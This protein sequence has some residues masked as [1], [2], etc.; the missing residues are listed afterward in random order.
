MTS[1]AT[2]SS[3][4]VLYRTGAGDFNGYDNFYQVLYMTGIST[5]N[6]YCFFYLVLYR[7]GFGDI[8]G[9]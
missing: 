8:N 5:F 1:T 7:T 3:T 6:V 2:S 4:L 9:N